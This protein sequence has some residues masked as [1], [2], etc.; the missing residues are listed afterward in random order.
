MSIRG[1]SAK[2][3]GRRSS[4]PWALQHFWW[5]LLTLSVVMTVYAVCTIASFNFGPNIV[6][7]TRAEINIPT[8]S[9]TSH[10]T[11]SSAAIT[12]FPPM[13]LHDIVSEE[14]NVSTAF[15]APARQRGKSRRI[16]LVI[17]F[18][19]R[20][21]HLEAFKRYWRWFAGVSPQIDLWDIYIVEQFDSE[22]FARGWLFNVGLAVANRDKK[23]CKD[24]QHWPRSEVSECVVVQD[25][26]YLPEEGV[27]YNQCKMPT[28]LSSEIDRYNWGVPYLQSAGGIVAMSAIDWSKINGF[29]N[30]YVG[31]GG[32][33]DELHTRV[34]INGLL[35]EG[36]HL[37]RPAKG[38]GRFSGEYM[39]S[40]DHTR[41]IADP[42]AYAANMAL[43]EDIKSGSDRWKTDGLSSLKFRI[44]DRTVND[45]ESK[46]YGIRYYHIKVHPGKRERHLA[47][48]PLAIPADATC[49]MGTT[50]TVWLRIGW[51]IP[52]DLRDLR[53]RAAV[54]SGCPNLIFL[55]VDVKNG[56]AKVLN[57]EDPRRL[58]VYYRSLNVPEEDGL[59]VA[60]Q[61]SAS[62]V[63]K[64][65][66]ALDLLWAPPT[67]Y[68][69]CKAY[70]K[71]YPRYKFFRG[72]H[73]D[74]GRWKTLQVRGSTF[75]AYSR[76][77]AGRNLIE[78]CHSEN[79]QHDVQRIVAGKH[80]EE[81]WS[82]MKWEG[83]DRIYVARPRKKGLLRL[84]TRLSFQ[85]SS[86]IL[87]PGVFE[88]E[89]FK[90]VF[91]F[92]P[93]LP[94]P[95]LPAVVVLSI[96]LRDD[97]AARFCVGPTGCSNG[98]DV[99]RFFVKPL[100]TTHTITPDLKEY[101][102]CSLEASDRTNDRHETICLGSN[103]CREGWKQRFRF[104]LSSEQ[105]GFTLASGPAAS[106]AEQR[107][108]LCVGSR[109]AAG[110][111]LTF[112]A[113]FAEHC[114]DS[115]HQHDFSLRAPSRADVAGAGVRAPGRFAILHE[116]L[117]CASFV[118]PD[119][120]ALLSDLSQNT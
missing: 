22:P 64:A 29:S 90:T 73:C 3:R 4:C 8:D 74:E 11:D 33:D 82:D 95:L 75:T 112:I 42:L 17:P 49:Q 28:Q 58:Y 60:D 89:P 93:V 68:T 76:P 77:V 51:P 36:K 26:D 118:C 56:I 120:L 83:E 34:K 111:G 63:E 116:D 87:P 23:T 32:E 71:E 69:V 31:W 19:D 96:S 67:S 80:C 110:A 108:P 103:C 119:T 1:S 104:A 43:L 13:S 30:K 70:W 39:H 99:L 113:R 37:R 105:P 48:L 40:F 109:V 98:T 66:A 78:V 86:R 5:V 85:P 54:A 57:D 47:R 72:R 92:D 27:N 100:Q 94:E 7:I 102:I 79:I 53:R 88:T 114:G 84:S 10:T 38:K 44:L 41:R 65:Y 81:K 2:K 20:E 12:T 50:K 52:W 55:L 46:D 24:L 35:W 62:E 97:G 45:S 107:R 115:E 117:E 14:I 106:E 59:I 101:S 91:D 21:S 61:R 15:L 16:S 6:N 25:I 18:R 9:Q